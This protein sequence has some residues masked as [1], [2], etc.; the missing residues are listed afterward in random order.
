L[1]W[2][3]RWTLDQALEKTVHWY[4]SFYRGS[5]QGKDATA[6]SLDQ[7]HAFILAAPAPKPTVESAAP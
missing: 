6:I 5:E 1:H 3:P 4:R 2:R 7:I